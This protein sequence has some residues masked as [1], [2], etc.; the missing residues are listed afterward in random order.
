[1]RTLILS[2]AGFALLG[3]IVLP[4]R[5]DDN[6]SSHGKKDGNKQGKLDVNPKSAQLYNQ[7]P[8]EPFRS[9]FYFPKDP[10]AKPD[11]FEVREV[12]LYDDYF[13]PSYLMV[14]SG[15]TVRFVN[16]GKHSHTT[17]CD[18]LWESGEMGRGAS[19]SI[20]FSRAGKY[21]HYC[22]HHRDM[23]GVIEVF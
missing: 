17:T 22:R 9:A 8:T 3:L 6:H 11:L 7:P 4:G 12:E 21:Y 19:F 1:M 10:P 14:A 15:K 20:T 16:R 2:A 13:S 23:R 18:W 5:A